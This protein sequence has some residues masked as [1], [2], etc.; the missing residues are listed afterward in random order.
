MAVR[1]SA[2]AGRVDA[3]RQQGCAK[4]LGLPLKFINIAQ[5]LNGAR[6]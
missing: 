1:P 5:V 4:R 2:F 3:V 6:A